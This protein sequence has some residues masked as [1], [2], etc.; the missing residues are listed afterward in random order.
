[1]FFKAARWSRT[2]CYIGIGISERDL[3][4]S[5]RYAFFLKGRGDQ[6]SHRLIEGR[7]NTF[8]PNVRSQAHEPVL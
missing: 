3:N 2:I 7:L 1:M 8:N 6:S 4:S 5:R